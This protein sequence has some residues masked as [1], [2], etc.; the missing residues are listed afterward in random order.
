[1][2][3]KITIT[4][5]MLLGLVGIVA[6]GV[7]YSAHWYAQQRIENSQIQQNQQHKDNWLSRKRAKDPFPKIPTISESS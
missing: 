5:G 6:I 2:N 3:K 7:W 4:I 1:M